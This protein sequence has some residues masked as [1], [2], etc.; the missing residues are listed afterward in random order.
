MNIKIG[1]LTLGLVAAMSGCIDSGSD[2]TTDSGS[3]GDGGGGGPATV[4]RI[5]FSGLVADGYLTGATVCLD[6]NNNKECDDDEP[7]TTSGNGGAFEIIDATQEQ[8]DTYPL[9]VEIVVGTTVDEDTITDA[10]PD[11]MTFEK[12]LTLTAPIGYEFIS[13]LTTMVQNEVEKGSTEAEAET[14]VQEKLGT[15][16][17]LDS[18]YIAGKAS[19]A[20]AEE[21]E[22]LHQVAQVTARVI[23]ENYDNLQSVADNNDDIS[24]DDLISKIVDEV[25]EALDEITEQVEEIAA[26]ADTEFDPDTVAQA[27]D[28]EVVDL[29]PETVVD[30][31]EKDKAEDEAVG[32]DMSELLKSPGLTWFETDQDGGSFDAFYAAIY[33]DNDGTFQEDEFSWSGFT[34]NPVTDSGES[35]P[36]Y[37]LTDSGW[38][39]IADYWTPDSITG[40]A[41]GRIE[42]VRAGGQVV[43][44]LISEEVDLN[45]LNKRVVMNEVD[46]GD[47]TW[48]NYLSATD[49][50]P[51]GS[52]GY[53]LADNGSDPTVVVEDWG[54]CSDTE[55]GGFCNSVNLRTNNAFSQATSMSQVLVAGAADLTGLNTFEEKANALVTIE[56]GYQGEQDLQLQAE[57]VGSGTSGTVNYYEV[58]HAAATIIF[59]KSATWAKATTGNAE[60]YVLDVTDFDAYEPNSVFSEI[61]GYVRAAEFPGQENS[62]GELRLLNASAVAA[63]TDSNFSLDNL[64]LAQTTP[65]TTGNS[66]WD[67]QQATISTQWNSTTEFNAAVITCLDGNAE[68]AYVE[69]ELKDGTARNLANGALTTYLSNNM[70]LITGDNGQLWFDWHVNGDSRLVLSYANAT[71]VPETITVAQLIRNLDQ[72]YVQSKSFLENADVTA[73]FVAGGMESHGL[74]GVNAFEIAPL[75]GVDPTILFAAETLSGTYEV[76]VANDGGGDFV[77]NENGTGSVHW[78]PDAEQLAQDPLH[79]GD[80]DT[81]TW[82]ADAQGRLVVT[83]INDQGEFSGV[84]RYSLT[85]G[86]QDSGTMSAEAINTN[87]LYQHLGDFTWSKTGEAPKIA[88]TTGDVDWNQATDPT[89]GTL[90]SRAD[91]D[92]AVAG[93]LGVDGLIPFTQANLVDTTFIAS[94]GSGNPEFSYSFNGYNPTEGAPIGSVITPEGTFNFT[95]D[96][97]QM[98]DVDPQAAEGEDITGVLILNYAGT[99]FE[100]ITMVAYD[101]TSNMA[102]LK[103]RTQFESDFPG[104]DKGNIWSN[105]FVK[106]SP[107]STTLAALVAVGIVDESRDDGTRNTYWDFVDNGNN[108]G[109]FKV[110]EREDPAVCYDLVELPITDNGSGSFSLDDSAT[111]GPSDIPVAWHVAADGRVYDDNDSYPAAADQNVI[112][113]LTMCL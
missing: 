13:P 104:V 73:S 53:T 103:G 95:W 11:G 23:S 28:E 19:G 60:V 113:G 26:D 49:T 69:Q 78:L 15:M 94:D 99:E 10:A 97:E 65:C 76:R 47:S 86:T 37:I 29:E 39:L 2:D 27:V 40:F 63:V 62:Q 72:A 80:D 98:Q 38:L 32:V 106:T 75:N 42:I 45:G 6:L 101:S 67:G 57:M 22:Q 43:E 5:S 111:G 35:D 24:I 112:S 68:V 61:E 7:S 71:G 74:I 17:D 25:F 90:K 82:I 21:Y 64:P 46:D 89:G 4:E 87:G 54:D 79:Q 31:I 18:D 81:L 88:C 48:G 70:G 56:I 55:Y 1:L 20:N 108:V 36:A 93:C 110:Y 100:Q 58:S 77:F 16:L 50:F 66:V 52:K 107:T 3:G 109:V 9:L 83:L 30:E 33:N 91:Y 44:R 14:A 96:I 102:S 51:A 8:R 59:V 85:A 41:D 105:L 12:P 34:F 84:D 92:A